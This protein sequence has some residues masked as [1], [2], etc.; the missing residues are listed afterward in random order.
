[1]MVVLRWQYWK[2][3]I[4]HLRQLY[5]VFIVSG[6]ISIVIL[7]LNLTRYPEKTGPVNE[8][9]VSVI[10]KIVVQSPE[11]VPEGEKRLL[12]ME[13]KEERSCQPHTHI[14]FLK[15]HKT[16]SSTIM[17]ILFRFGESHNLTF[18]LPANYQPQLF[19]PYY[20]TAY[21]VEG[22]TT[23]TRP[24]Y[25]IMCHH[26]RF[27]LTEV[28]KVMPKDT[29][30]FTLMRNP[31][32]LMES[33]FSYYKN[34]DIFVNAHSLQEYLNN[35]YNYYNQT[36]RNSGYGKNLMAFDLGLD[37]HEPETPKHFKLAQ[38]TIETMFNL[39][40]ITEYF[41]ESL[42]LLKDALCWSFDDVLSFPLNSR[43]DSNRKVL[44]EE[45]QDKVKTWNQLDWQL[46]VYFNKSFWE[47][48]DKF[49]QDRMQ[50]EVQELQRRRAA[51]SE[52]CLQGQVDDPAKIKDNSLRPFQAGIHKILGYNLK[53][54]LQKDEERLCRRLVTP[55]LQY[56][57]QLFIKQNRQR[58]IKAK[59]ISQQKRHRRSEKL[60][61]WAVHRNKIRQRL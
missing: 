53:P 16:A 15:T 18:A 42:I 17:N 21:F 44:S 20:F 2:R 58:T 30:Y 39:V 23:K 59:N 56:T 33:S 24:K 1:M 10:Q 60:Q 28:E 35:P 48:V 13:R 25:D 41:D 29:F 52:I 12:K 34:V 61:Q 31:V 38:K 6:I 26:M 11:Q 36:S 40:L 19:Y 7:F 43:N 57:E 55:E 50:S 46:Y 32:S 49:G 9:N 8:K 54:G 4:K 45:T 51:Q 22:Y 27:H 5:I 14:F 37:Q 47:M 3:I